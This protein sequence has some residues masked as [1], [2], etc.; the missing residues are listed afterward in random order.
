M[1]VGVTMLRGYRIG[2]GWVLF[3]WFKDRMMGF[4]E[5]TF[6]WFAMG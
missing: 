4:G 5:L 6:T 1:A 3:W 2:W